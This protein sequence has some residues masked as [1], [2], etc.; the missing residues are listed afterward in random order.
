MTEQVKVSWKLGNVELQYE[1]N[2]GFLKTEL[3]K[4]FQ[5][6]LEIYKSGSKNGELESQKLS[7]VTKQPITEIPNN[8]KLELSV[9][10]IA[11]K[12]DA[13]QGQDFALAACAY[14][15]L[16]EQKTTFSYNEIREAMK[17]AH[18]FYDEN[19]RKNLPKYIASLM[20]K[21]FL[22]ERSP[23]IYAIEGTKLKELQTAL[24]N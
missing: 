8:G 20:R 14:L 17:T 4:L 18:Q 5:E 24:A 22:L 3:P 7:T 2:E 1:G 10:T 16:V 9:N 13:K 15:S 21:R 6:L 12:L 23:H 19:Q 11:T